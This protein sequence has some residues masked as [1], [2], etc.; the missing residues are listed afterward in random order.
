MP[1]A[2]IT[3]AAGFIGVHL[4]EELLASGFS[5]SGLCRKGSGSNGRLPADVKAYYDLEDLPEADIFYHLAWES[6]SGPGRADALIQSR[7][8]A[9]TAEALMLAKKRGCKRFIA[10]G[11]I[12]ER[13]AGQI[14]Q[15]GKFSGPDF[16]ILSKD[17]ARRLANQL[18][19]KLDIGFAWCTVCHPIGRYIKPEQLMASVVSDLLNGVSPALGPALINY[20]MIDVRDAALALR[21]LGQAE[22]L[23]GREYYIGSGRAKPL[24]EWF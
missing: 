21:L 3:G 19:Y 23:T 9:F 14:S 13:L 2:I 15:S 24:R 22:R 7:N 16:Y 11:T 12:Y 4:A 1:H 10:M 17:Y 5:V 8:A 6:A 20:D 18:A